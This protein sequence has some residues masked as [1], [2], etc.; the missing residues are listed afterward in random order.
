[1]SCDV[2]S[3]SDSTINCIEET[4]ICDSDAT[5]ISNKNIKPIKFVDKTL[6]TKQKKVVNGTGTCSTIVAVPHLIK[7][8]V[9]TAKRVWRVLL[10]SGSNGDLL[11]VHEGSRSV[12]PSKERFAP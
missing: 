11:F 8:G 5:T 10:D 1:M 2:G 9:Q 6:S 3:Y 7:K 12:I 4:F